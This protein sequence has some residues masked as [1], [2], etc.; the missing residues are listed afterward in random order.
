MEWDRREVLV[1]EL[2]HFLG[3]THSPEATSVMRPQLGDSQSRPWGFR[4]D[5]D[6]LNT[7]AVYLLAEELRFRKLVALSQLSTGTAIRLR[8]L[9]RVAAES[10]PEDPARTSLANDGSRCR[11]APRSARYGPGRTRK[12]GRRRTAGRRPPDRPAVGDRRARQRQPAISRRRR[13][14][15]AGPQDGR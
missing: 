4:I 10:M 13:E 7:L 14:R 2:G 9:Y 12:I 11:R 3:A 8:Q 5:F 1:H 6:P 15:S